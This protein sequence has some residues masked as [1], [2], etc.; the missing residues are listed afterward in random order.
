MDEKTYFEGIASY[1]LL[2][3]K[4]V[5][6]NFL[7]DPSVAKRIVDSLEAKEGERILEIGCGAGSLS[8]FLSQGPAKSIAIDI[9]EAMV[10]KVAADFE[11][12]EFFSATLGNAMRFDYSPFDKIIGN[13]PYYITSGII[14]QILLKAKHAT[15]CIFMI[16]KEAAERILSK[17]GSKDYSPLSVYI[18]IVSKARK[19]FN[20]S[21]NAFAP[22][23]HVDSTVIELEFNSRHDERAEKAYRFASAM[24][25]QRRKTVLNNLKNYLHSSEKALAILEKMGIPQTYRAEQISPEQYWNIIESGLLDR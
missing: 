20:V 12:S 18:A 10:T 3:K 24:F 2:A 17:Q 22:A 25:L 11:S 19:L 4:E 21:R 14:E 6:Q 13:L 16:Q 15:R 9:D 5:G 23:P 1:K 7:I 8:Y